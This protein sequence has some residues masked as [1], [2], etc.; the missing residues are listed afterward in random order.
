MDE[1]TRRARLKPA[2]IVALPIALLIVVV[3]PQIVPWL[4]VL[5]GIIV[6]GGVMALISQFGR[7][8]GKK[9]EHQLFSL[10]GAIPTTRMLRHRDAKNTVTVGRYHTKL[11]HLIPEL[12]IPTSEQEQNNPAAA[13]MVYESCVT[14]LRDKTRDKKRFPLVFEENCNY[15]FRRNLWGMKPL[16][17][18]TSAIG[19][20]GIVAFVT[21]NYYLKGLVIPPIGIIFGSVN[22]GLLLAWITRV[23]PRWVRTC[24][25]AYAE[26]LLATCDDL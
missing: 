26:R 7:D 22:L 11:Q 18:V 15:G 4:R 25:E 20:A 21:S 16:G 14:F 5:W 9:K 10:W 19:I 13:D 17:L 3:F 2:L 23:T 12:R 24:A 6:G 1:Y 8:W